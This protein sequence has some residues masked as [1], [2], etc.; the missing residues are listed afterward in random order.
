MIPKD[1]CGSPWKN[2][3]KL[4][5]RF[6][7]AALPYLTMEPTM[8]LMRLR[9]YRTPW[10]AFMGAYGSHVFC[11]NPCSPAAQGPI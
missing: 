4:F 7:L 11:T 10:S 1:C 3:G 6:P 8:T 5:P 2:L 9:G